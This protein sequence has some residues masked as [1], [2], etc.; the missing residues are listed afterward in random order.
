MT[1][2]DR[3]DLQAQINGL[4]IVKFW[5]RD[6]RDVP[7]PD[8]AKLH[9]APSRDA[10]AWGLMVAVSWLED[11]GYTVRLWPYGARAFRGK[12][13]PIRNTAGILRRRAEVE[14]LAQAGRLPSSFTW[15]ALD[16]A[17]DI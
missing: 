6:G 13:W 9:E 1:N 8:G 14:A 17:F 2:P 4:L 11:H 16:F 12:P 15:S 7:H 3:V 10:A 5:Q